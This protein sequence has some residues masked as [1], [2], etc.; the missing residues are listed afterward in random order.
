M[1]GK[2]KKKKGGK[3]A[4]IAVP[5]TPNKV[6]VL[7]KVRKGMK[8]VAPLVGLFNPVAG[9][10]LGF[11]G[12]G[13]YQQVGNGIEKA[14]INTNSLV[15]PLTTNSIPFMHTSNEAMRVTRREFIGN[16]PVAVS[17]NDP[18]GQPAYVINPGDAVTFPWLH[19]LA[20]NFQQWMPLGIVFHYRATCGVT[21][22]VSPS[23]GVVR[24]ATQYDVYQPLFGGDIARITNHFFS[25]TTS[26]FAS[27]DHAV[28]C[29]MEQT[30][31]KPLWIRPEA[32][33]EHDDIKVDS[34]PVHLVEHRAAT[35][36]AR[37]YDL[38]RLEFLN[39]GSPTGG[40]YVSGELWVTYDII[41]MKPRV[42][43]TG[44]FTYQSTFTVPV[45]TQDLTVRNE[46]TMAL[47]DLEL[48]VDP[49]P[50]EAPLEEKV[51]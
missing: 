41:L 34:G 10:A 12:K 48:T 44:G 36:D 33:L 22:T 50:P 19:N 51:E 21:S 15:K 46:Y 43:L 9:A 20:R 40:A 8:T 31:I 16:I 24:M 5:P 18:A 14:A 27:T 26:P 37:L 35:F 3:R 32:L 28:E 45:E 39:S 7:D 4:A 47:E 42:Q 13:D 49:P 6:G 25:Q 23:L 30:A 17:T 11:L 2:G 38:G 1:P 29:A